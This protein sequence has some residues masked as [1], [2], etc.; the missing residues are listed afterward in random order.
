MTRLVLL[1][2]L[3]FLSSTSGRQIEKPIEPIFI[4]QEAGIHQVSSSMT[5]VEKKV[6]DATVRIYDKETGGHGTGSVIDYK[7]F[8]LVLTAQHV[9]DGELGSAYYAMRDDEIKKM[10]LI[11]AD[12]ANDIA[13]LFLVEDFEN[14]VPMKFSPRKDILDIGEEITYSGFPSG[15]QLMT[16]KGKVAGYEDVPDIGKQIILHTYGWF[17]CSGAAIYDS[18]GRIAGI[19]WA[20]DVE[21]FPA[22][23]IVED[24]IWVTPINNLNIDEALSMICG[25]LESRDR[26]CKNNKKGTL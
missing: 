2:S 16:F 5:A 6:R 24:L 15:H 12:E 14:L 26:A 22:P 21:S 11:Y 10:Y 4:S 20:V 25:R 1:F 9:V 3:L 8:T 19:L 13:V 23:R 17:G 7:D 18:K